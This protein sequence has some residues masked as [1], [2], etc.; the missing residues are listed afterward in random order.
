[1]LVQEAENFVVIRRDGRRQ[2]LKITQD[3][4][5]GLQIAAGDLADHEWVHQY[6]A[7]Q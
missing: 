6:L 1:M 7:I 2:P 5:P 4:G 3:L